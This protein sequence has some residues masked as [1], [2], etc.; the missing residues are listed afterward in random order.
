MHRRMAIA[1]FAAALALAA[2]LAL[3]AVPMGCGGSETTKDRRSTL[4][5]PELAVD[6]LLFGIVDGDSAA[7]LS[8]LPPAW[9]GKLRG[10][11]GGASDEE[12]GE[13]IIDGL[14]S[15][16]PYTEIVSISYLVSEREDGSSDVWYWGEFAET[17][18]A[19]NTRKVKVDEAEARSF[20]LVETG[21]SWC[22][23]VK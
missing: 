23:N 6:Y 20:N 16:F 4:S 12:L 3:A 22:L 2:C 9:L 21:G 17:D 5:P 10:D 1:R 19:G 8:V 7:V 14:R 15:E 11:A 18:S 13:M